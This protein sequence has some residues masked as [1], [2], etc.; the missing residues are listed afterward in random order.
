MEVKPGMEWEEQVKVVVSA[1][2]D[3]NES[4][5]LQWVKSQLSSAEAIRREWE[6]ANTAVPSIEKTTPEISEASEAPGV[7]KEQPK[8]AVICKSLYL[9]LLHVLLC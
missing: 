8:P 7:E 2:L 5:H 3:R 4:E 6:S 1:L 9:V